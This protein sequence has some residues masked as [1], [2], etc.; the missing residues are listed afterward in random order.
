MSDDTKQTTSSVVA[1][2]LDATL[3]RLLQPTRYF[4][5][6]RDVVHDP[7]LTIAEKRAILSSW[8]SDACAIDSEPTLRKMPGSVYVAS[9]DDVIDALE[10]LDNLAEDQTETTFA[11]SPRERRNRGGGFNEGP[12]GTSNWY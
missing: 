2:P 11:A 7:T 3:E 9:F 12:A 10:E 8:A 6:P 5:H 1:E 4:Q